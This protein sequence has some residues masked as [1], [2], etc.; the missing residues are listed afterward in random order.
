VDLD[1]KDRVA[2]VTAASRGLGRAVA[3]ALADEGVRTVLCARSQDELEEVASGLAADSVTVSGDLDNPALPDRLV[4]VALDRFGRLD[5]MVAN[6]GGPPKGRAIEVSDDQLRAALDANLLVSVRLARAALG[7]MRSQRWGR[8][9]MIA[10]GS[11]KQPMPEL[12]LSNTARPGLWGWA[13][14]AAAEVADEGITI[15]LMC[16][17]LHAT[18]RAREVGRTNGRRMGDPEDFGKIVAFFCSPHTR[19]VTGTTVVVDGGQVMGL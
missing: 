15:N 6:N 19:F 11:V 13:K 14:T 9:C 17:G 4:E 5:I 18:G 8:I 12:A 2:V 3:E 16:P 10:S 1:L 7:P